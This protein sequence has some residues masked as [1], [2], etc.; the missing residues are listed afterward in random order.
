MLG[1]Y[2][3]LVLLS[4]ALAGILA[5]FLLEWRKQGGGGKEVARLREELE[6]LRRDYTQLK[7]D[8]NDMLLGLNAAVSRLEACLDP[9]SRAA[10]PV[11][12]PPHPEPPQRQ[13]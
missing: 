5:W 8:H 9:S 10:G 2:V 11:P 7:A 13:L 4:P 1:V 12:E 3:L 6:E